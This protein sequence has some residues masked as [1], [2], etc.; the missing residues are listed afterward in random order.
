MYALCPLRCTSTPNIP[1]S[2]V[3]ARNMAANFT[4]DSVQKG[5][6]TKG[7]SQVAAQKA[8]EAAAAAAEIRA[9]IAKAVDRGSPDDM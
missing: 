8:K 3:Q 4:G 6:E 2:L 9:A 7:F 5:V 1:C